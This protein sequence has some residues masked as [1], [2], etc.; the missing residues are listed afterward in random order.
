MVVKVRGPWGDRPPKKPRV[1]AGKAALAKRAKTKTKRKAAGGRAGRGE[2]KRV[3]AV[4][5]GLSRNRRR[6]GLGKRF[7]RPVRGAASEL[8]RF[9]G[10]FEQKFLIRQR[11][12]TILVA[13][14]VVWA[15]WTFLIGD[16]GILRL[17]H[18]KHQNDR[19]APEIEELERRQ[20]ELL[21]EVRALTNPEAT[22]FLEKV[23]REEH[24]LVKDGEVLVRFYAD[25]EAAKNEE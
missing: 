3:E 5:R 1:G 23:A 22:D 9:Y 25:A 18:V 15:A 24:A 12:R 2:R 8:S 16:A 11:L 7:G 20:E 17:L 13:L 14:A 21:Q 4:R 10:L 6:G 19:L